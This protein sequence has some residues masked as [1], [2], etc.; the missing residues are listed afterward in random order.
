MRLWDGNSREKKSS[1]RRLSPARGESSPGECRTLQFKSDQRG[2]II[3]VTSSGLEMHVHDPKD[4]KKTT[5]LVL[6][7]IVHQ[8]ADIL[9]GSFAW[10]EHERLLSV[11]FAGTAR[12]DTLKRVSKNR[13]YTKT[14][15]AKCV[16]T[17]EELRYE[18]PR[19]CVGHSTRQ[20]KDQRKLDFRTRSTIVLR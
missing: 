3:T 6:K 10:R 5:E 14:H 20:G 18:P 15:R 16:Q 17:S 7:E 9:E 19:A 8:L 11:N 13:L 12:G 4:R 1:I 2:M